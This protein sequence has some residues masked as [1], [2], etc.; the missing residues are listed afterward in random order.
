MEND[1]SYD[2]F[3]SE[4]FGGNMYQALAKRTLID[5]PP[6]AYTNQEIML[7]WNAMGV[8]GEA[9]ELADDIK[10]AVFH[11]H[12]IDGPKLVKECG[13]VLWYVAAILTCLNT[14]MS[15]AMARNIEKLKQRYPDGFSTDAS[16]GWE[17]T[18]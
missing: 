11:D 16:K 10:K 9:G 4:E 8:A 2:A 15:V 5:A 3:E 13:D 14:P 1:K 17:K 12:G 7:V 18:R 6:R